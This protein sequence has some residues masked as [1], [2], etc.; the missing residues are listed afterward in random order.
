MTRPVRSATSRSL[1]GE[2]VSACAEPMKKSNTPADI[3]TVLTNANIGL[4]LNRVDSTARGV[5][6]AQDVLSRRAAI[7]CAAD[8]PALRYRETQEAT[9]RRVIGRVI[10]SIL[11]CRH[12]VQRRLS[13]EQI[14]CRDF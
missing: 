13:V 8:L 7:E 6:H 9:D 1:R 2:I 5:A 12:Y 10:R 14:L 4:S 11:K 3:T